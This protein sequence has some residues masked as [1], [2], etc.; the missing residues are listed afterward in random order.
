MIKIRKIDLI[1]GLFA[2]ML[3]GLTANKGLMA[4]EATVEAPLLHHILIEVTDLKASIRFYHDCL[5]LKIGSISGDFAQLESVGAGIFLWQKRWNFEKGRAD[6]PRGLGIYPH[7]E[8]QDVAGAIDRFRK[9][10]YGIVQE[11]KTYDW[12]TEAFVRDPDGYIIALVTMTG[13][14]N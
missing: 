11:P 4:G 2:L 1:V 13:K 9:G 12:G 6:D 7:F 8:V 14:R 10:G 3:P 5:G